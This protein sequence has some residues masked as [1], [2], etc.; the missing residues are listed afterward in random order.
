MK[1]PFR[2]RVPTEVAGDGPH[3]DR[4]KQW[5]KYQFKVSGG[6]LTYMCKT[7]CK[8]MLRRVFFK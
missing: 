3:P 5:L 4:T 8:R 2:V 7:V 6:A 1:V